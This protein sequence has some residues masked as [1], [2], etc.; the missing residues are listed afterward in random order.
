MNTHGKSQSGRS[1]LLRAGVAGALMVAAACGLAPQ[2][3]SDGVRVRDGVAPYADQ[4]SLQ[5]CIGTQRLLPSVSR[6]GTCRA[7]E[8]VPSAC[9]THE[10][11]LTPESCVCGQCM[12]QFCEATSDCRDGL[13]CAGRPK[14]CQPRCD[15]DEQCGPYG[16]CNGGA[17]ETACWDQSDC[18]TGELCLVGRCAAVGCGPDGP[19]CFDGETCLVQAAVGAVTGVSAITADDVS[20]TEASTRVVA[21]A[22]LQTP[23]AM[24]SI[25]RFESA[26][27]RR[28]VA[29]PGQGIL[30]PGGATRLSNPAVLRTPDGLYLFVEVDGGSSI[31][32]A[33][34]PS[35]AGT[36]VSTF[37]TVATPAGWAS[38]LHAPSAAYVNE[39][40]VFA[41]AGA[42]SEGVG[43]GY[44]DGATFTLGATATLTPASFED[45]E[46]FVGVTTLG[47]PDLRVER[48]SAG[49]NILRL[50]ADAYGTALPVGIEGGSLDVPTSSVVFAAAVVPDEG[51]ALPFVIAADNPT[52]GRVQN[53]APLEEYDP[54]VVRM[55]NTYLIYFADD[56]GPRVAQNPVRD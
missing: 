31:A 48:S 41:V 24:S 39:R 32:R 37:E 4:G 12:V 35:G 19:N 49:R 53:F 22:E 46:R 18:P 10:D 5:F 8:Q 26:D 40:V 47:G 7:D 17:C 29:T 55:G 20:D 3:E 27:G 43:V 44:L 33:L 2:P 25:V 56:V 11:C 28:F 52:F 15:S 1:A 14:R 36:S 16:V 34:D 30:P 23:S 6:E 54:S 9:E 50:Y 42:A 51:D 21:F 13:V 45:P 38:E